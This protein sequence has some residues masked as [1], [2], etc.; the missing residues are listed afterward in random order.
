MAV[1]VLIVVM[2]LMLV[3]TAAVLV[4][5]MMVLMVMVVMLLHQRLCHVFLLHRMAQLL[6]AQFI[7]GGNHDGCIVI[8]L[9]QQRNCRL[10][11]FLGHLL[12]TA[13]DDGAGVFHLIVIELAEVLHVDLHLAA[14]HHGDGAV[15]RHAAAL[16]RSLFRCGDHIGEL[17]HA[18]GLDQN[19]IGVEL[20]LHFL[21]RLAEVTHKRAADAARGHLRDLHAG[22]LQKAAVHADL[23]KFIFDQHKLLTL[24]NLRNELADEGGLARTEEAGNHIDLRHHSKPLS[25]FKYF[26]AVRIPFF[27][28]HCK[29]FVTS[30][31]NS[32]LFDIPADDFTS[33]CIFSQ[34]AK[35]RSL[36][37]SL[38][39]V[40]I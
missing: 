29:C 6:A 13:E 1:A 17:T 5:V 2:V 33:H 9:T 30:F 19:T 31:Q 26:S 22:I 16:L 7:P 8:L 25:L 28:F 4:M 20:L 40:Q 37:A 21:Q 3:T 11:L 39:L 15:Q 27:P 23:T 18:G 38:S 36:A 14:V 32:F 12:G 10:Q 24:V 35:K 34:D